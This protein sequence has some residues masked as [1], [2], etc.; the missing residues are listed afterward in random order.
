[1]NHSQN[2][3]KYSNKQYTLNIL[4][5]TST[6]D[7]NTDMKVAFNGGDIELLEYGSK[8][9]SLLIDGKILYVDRYAMVDKFLSQHICYCYVYFAEH[10][11]SK[12]IDDGIGEPDPK[13]TF[14]HTFIVTNIKPLERQ[15]HKVK[16]Q[17]DLTSI[18]WFRCIANVQYTNYDKGQQPVLE[19]LKNCIINAGLKVDKDSFSRTQANVP[20]NYIT[21]LNDNLFTVSDFLMQKLYYMPQKDDSVKFF[22]YDIFDDKYRLLDLKDEKTSLGTYSTLLSMFKTNNEAIIQQDP[23]NFGAFQNPISKTG[24]YQTLFDKKMYGYSYE[25]NDFTVTDFKSDENL[26]YMNNKIDNNNYEM[27]YYDMPRY[28]SL[29]FYQAG[30]YWNNSID[31]YTDSTSMLEENNALILNIT[32]DVKRQAGTYTLITL[33]RSLKNLTNDSKREL[34]KE[35]VKYKNY[36][37]IWYNSKVQ[38]IISPSKSSYRQKVVLFRN[39]IPKLRATT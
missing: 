15:Q 7:E 20:M 13:R 18:N 29:Q 34:E 25:K 5:Y 38:N 32:G 8:L 14:S 10:H 33:D 39:F 12:S 31:F 1:M 23:T 19:I 17:I 30:S 37:G 4:L 11:H 27:K 24:V 35:K 28:Q 16:Y 6:G 21:K 9:N 2:T 3:F 36:E 22:F 26:K